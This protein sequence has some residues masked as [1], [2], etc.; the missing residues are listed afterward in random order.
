MDGCCC[1]FG[2]W[3]PHR[4][5]D[6]CRILRPHLRYFGNQWAWRL[7]HAAHFRPYL[8]ELQRVTGLV[9]PVLNQRAYYGQGVIVWPVDTP[10]DYEL[11]ARCDEYVPIV[12]SRGVVSVARAIAAERGIFMRVRRSHRSVGECVLLFP[13]LVGTYDRDGTFHVV[14]GIARYDDDGWPRF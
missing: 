12:R 5:S 1:M 13:H 9:R 6:V 14:S 10:T 11:I 3:E 2:L 4:K 7:H 8:L